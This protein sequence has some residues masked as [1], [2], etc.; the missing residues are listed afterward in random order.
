LKGGSQEIEKEGDDGEDD[1]ALELNKI[2]PN[3]VENSVPVISCVEGSKRRK[4]NQLRLDNTRRTPAS[5]INL[6]SGSENSLLSNS[7]GQENEEEKAKLVEAAKLLSI[8]REVGFTF[9]EPRGE[10]MKQLV[11]HENA[12]RAKKMDW[13]QREGDQ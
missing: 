4:E 9:E 2:T 7:V 11:D 8:Q 13:E 3:Q 5:G 10:I 6:I 1:V 12:D